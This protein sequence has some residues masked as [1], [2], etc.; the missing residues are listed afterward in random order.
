MAARARQVEGGGAPWPGSWG[1][2]P[3]RSWSEQSDWTGRGS[4]QQPPWPRPASRGSKRRRAPVTWP[5]VCRC[6][7]PIRR[8]APDGGKPACCRKLQVIAADL[9]LRHCLQAVNDGGRCWSSTPVCAAR[10]T[11]AASLAGHLER[12]A[13]PGHRRRPA[14]TT[15]PSLA[16]NGMDKGCK[17]SRPSGSVLVRG[18][19][20]ESAIIAAAC[21]SVLALSLSGSKY[22]SGSGADGH[23]LDNS[24]KHSP[25]QLQFTVNHDPWCRRPPHVPRHWRRQRPHHACRTQRPLS[26]G[27]AI[28]DGL[29]LFMSP[30]ALTSLLPCEE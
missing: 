30:A 6:A 13:T 4:E 21:S 3:G 15:Q 20:C 25:Q 19:D 1:A 28:A 23:A 26:A 12:A 29:M 16:P 11:A 8:R 18:P 14:S 27:P 24:A 22:Y 17:P 9:F 7:P 5:M 2:D 10:E